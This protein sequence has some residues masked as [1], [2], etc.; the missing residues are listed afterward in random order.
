MDLS[1]MTYTSQH[2]CYQNERTI[3]W[4]KMHQ[5][6]MNLQ[7]LLL[8]QLAKIQKLYEYFS[9]NQ[10]LSNFQLINVLYCVVGKYYPI[11]C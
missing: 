4:G 2:Q 3:I 9:E 11:K 5:L 10:L 1:A 7:H 6:V 8:H